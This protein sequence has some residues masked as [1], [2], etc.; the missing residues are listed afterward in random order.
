MVLGCPGACGGSLVGG[1]GSS[2]GVLARV[3]AVLGASWAGLEASWSGRGVIFRHLG[4]VVVSSTVSEGCQKVQ[5][6]NPKPKL[7]EKG[8]KL[9]PVSRSFSDRFASP[10]WPSA[11]PVTVARR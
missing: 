10:T 6:G 7:S 2:W 1:L 5:K 8:L 3:G 4:V 9:Y 11:L